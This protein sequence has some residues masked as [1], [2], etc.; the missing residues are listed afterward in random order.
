[1]S[2][3]YGPLPQINI[4]IYVRPFVCPSIRLSV[5]L[6]QTYIVIIRCTLARI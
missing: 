3:A 4:Y 1:M 6:G 5:C 2:V